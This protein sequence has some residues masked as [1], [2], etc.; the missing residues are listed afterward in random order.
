MNV[1][2]IIVGQGIAGSLL[3]RNL[4]L[5]ENSVMV[6]DEVNNASASRMAGGIINPVTGKRLV[7]SW[8]IDELLPFA[9]D[10]YRAIEKELNIAI[11]QQ[12]DTFDFPLSLEA[13]DIFKGKLGDE[14]KYLHTVT[15]EAVWAK[16]FRFN[17]GIGCITPCLLVQMDP[18]INAWRLRLKNM[19]ALTEEK[20]MWEDFKMEQDH[21]TY[22]NIRAQKII[23][24]E[25]SG[26]A[27]NPWF[28]LLPW[29]KDKGEALIASI[30]G[31]PGNFIFKQGISIVPWHDGLFWIGAT[32]DWKFADMLPTPSFRK[33]T[34]EQLDYWL[35]IPYKIVDHLVSQ[36]PANMERKP[37]VGLH[38]VHTSIGILN[39]LGGK[40]VSMAPYFANM[41]AGYLV[42]QSPILPEADVRRFTKILSR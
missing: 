38:P 20:F 1:D 3:S 28:S 34:E 22:K 7:R 10:T 12:C 25:G 9:L 41:L 42:H 32:H 16:Y 19:G 31:L 6:I 15:D 24:C 4:L 14:K 8:M 23:C 37:F 17:Y 40:G 18:F 33:K 26:G 30:P 11:V 35:K 13:S 39:G 5:A 29:A 27:D 36:R 21:I 2:Y